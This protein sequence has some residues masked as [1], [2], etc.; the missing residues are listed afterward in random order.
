FGEGL[1][2]N[3]Y[4]FFVIDN[5]L[6]SVD[7]IA[8][9]AAAIHINT[10][11]VLLATSYLFRASLAKRLSLPMMLPF[12]ALTF[13]VMKRRAGFLTLGIAL[14]LLVIILF[15]ENRRLFYG[16]MPVLTVTAVIYIGIFWNS[17][18]ALGLPAQAIKSVFATDQ[19]A[20][21]DR[22]SDIYRVLEN[23]NIDF[24]IHQVP[25]TGVGFGKP[26]YILVEM[27]DISFF[28]FWEYIT[29]NSIVWIWMK[30]GFGGFFALI[31]L[32]GWSL[33]SGLEVF[34]RL[35]DPD[36]KAVMMTAVLYVVMHFTYAYV[37]MSWDIES[38]IYLGC[39]LG[40]INGMER[41][42]SRPKI[43]LT[44][45]YPWSP[46]PNVLPDI[47]PLETVSAPNEVA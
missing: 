1:I 36:L 44:K 15:Q 46:E 11:F 32:I 9:H 23:I 18:G 14:V 6:S 42:A 34:Q 29:H 22:S 43:A 20:A 25:L 31:A 45:R 27:P 38:M 26:F 24:T 37:D 28:T 12:V 33:I 10:F 17:S 35:L 21:E 13:M 30:V 47:L 5:D 4:Y 8:A 16:I 19:A 3:H 2:G 7:S 39:M 40:I 41:I